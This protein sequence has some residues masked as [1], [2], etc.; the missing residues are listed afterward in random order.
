MIALLS[1]IWAAR[2]MIAVGLAAAAAPV[3]W[4]Y[5]SRLQSRAERAETEVVRLGQDLDAAVHA[6][7]ANAQAVE[8]AKQDAALTIA[9]LERERNA[10]AAR[11]E[12]VQVIY[13]EITRAPESDD[14]PVAPVL[15]R[16]LDSLRGTTA[17]Q[18]GH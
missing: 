3:A 2:N 14:G 9:A 8:R 7:D 11:G 12:R 15:A 13:K 6:A 5:I 1:S 16:T 10:L 18:G 4:I 17:A